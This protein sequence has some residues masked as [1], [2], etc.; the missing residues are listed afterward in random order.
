MTFVRK[1][2]RDE[3]H[4]KHKAVCSYNYC[5]FIG[6]VKVIA[7]DVVSPTRAIHAVLSPPDT[8]PIPSHPIPSHPISPALCLLADFITAKRTLNLRNRSSDI[9]TS[10][11]SHI[12]QFGDV[13]SQLLGLPYVSGMEVSGRSSLLCNTYASLELATSPSSRKLFF[14]TLTHPGSCALPPRVMR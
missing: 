13:P 12:R 3:S 6:L 7:T 5:L 11:S 14:R 10:V 4:R 8:S 2:L 9:A 1:P